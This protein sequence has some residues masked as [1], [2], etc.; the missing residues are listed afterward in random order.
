M[1]Q[2]FKKPD[3]FR[4]RDFRRSDYDSFAAIHD[5]LFPSHQ[6]FLER[7]EHED[8]CFENSVYKMKR[9]VAENE[10][11]EVLAVGGVNH[12]FFDY[13]PRKFSLS[14]EVHPR[15]QRNGIGNMLYEN[16][17]AQL[18]I[19]GAEVAWSDVLA[20]LA[21]GEAFV[22]KRGFAKKRT[23]VESTL[24]L[25]S[26]KLDRLSPLERTLRDQGIIITDL[27]AE[28]R[29]DKDT[30]K[31]LFDVED[32]ADKDV[33]TIGEH[34][35]MTYQDYVALILNS[36]IFVWEGSFVAKFRDSYVG[37][38]TVLRNGKNDALDQGFTAVRPEFRGKGIA[39]AVKLRVAKHA[40]ESGAKLLITRNDS[41]NDPM[42][43]VNQKLGFVS[44]NEW[45][46]FE[47]KIA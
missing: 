36:S 13:H 18:Q 32:S 42:L 27:A 15:W 23:L 30:G 39:Q 44:R 2:S 47:K 33:P 28:M 3:R 21:S 22:K 35:S 6:F 9:I 25:A 46:T 17:L 14:I 24:D 5:S 20:G 16:L 11:G 41:R 19:M 43:A 29:D 12:V 38:S 26:V 4:V 45:I 10:A 31:K 7:T 8:A 40:K 34:I 1:N 37:S